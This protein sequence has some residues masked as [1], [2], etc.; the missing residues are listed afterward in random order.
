[1]NPF[2]ASKIGIHMWLRNLTG[3]TYGYVPS[4]SME[5]T[6]T[7]G[8]LIVA[9]TKPLYNHL[10]VVLLKDPEDPYNFVVKRII[11]VGGDVIWAGKGKITRNSVILE[12]PYIKEPIKYYLPE[13]WL[14]D[15]QVFVLGD[16]RNNSDDCH[17]TYAGLPQELILGKVRWAFRVKSFWRWRAVK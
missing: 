16:N 9:Q 13:I 1:M 15:D 8:D 4:G 11:A 14:K 17:F 7:R 6:L 5:P 2:K 12:E 10:D 3:Y